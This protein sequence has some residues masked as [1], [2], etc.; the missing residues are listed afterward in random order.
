M[1][2]ALCVRAETADA[3]RYARTA[4]GKDQRERTGN[5]PTASMPGRQAGAA[6]FTG[7]LWGKDG[8]SVIEA[9][10]EETGETFVVRGDDLYAVVVE[11]ASPCGIELEDR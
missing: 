9:V 6:G 11:L 10:N 5:A 2:S 1:S 3:R 4:A 8:Q 7:Q